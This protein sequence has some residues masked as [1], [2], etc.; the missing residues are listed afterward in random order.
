MRGIKLPKNVQSLMGFLIIPFVTL[1]LFGII[2]YYLV[3]PA[4]A[5]L[6]Q[7][8]L[9]LLNSIPSSMKIGGAALVGCMLAFDMG[10]PVNKAAW[11]FSFSLLASGVYDW[12]GIVGVVTVIPPMAAAIA[13]WIRPQLFTEPER[14]ASVPAFIVG[15]TVAT[16][17][18]IPYALAAP[19]PMISANV[20]A[21]GVAGALSMA[22]GVQRIAPGIGIFDPL[23]G[24]ISPAPAYYIALGVGLALNVILIVV[25]KSIWLKRRAKAD[26][27]E[28]PNLSESNVDEI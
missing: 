27:D 25:F 21:G 16:E 13:C 20:I 14:D 19:L 26:A 5:F 2:T 11:F 17:P 23:L 10:G 8:L 9:D 4:M 7:S 1:F 28:V 18:A 12:Y 24:L 6:M 3:G 15:A 22:L